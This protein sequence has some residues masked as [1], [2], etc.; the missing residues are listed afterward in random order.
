MFLSLHN[1]FFFLVTWTF[2]K[3]NLN[4]S[5]RED[6]WQYF[7]YCHWS[8]NC[9]VALNFNTFFTRKTHQFVSAWYMLLRQILILEQSWAV[10]SFFSQSIRNLVTTFHVSGK[11]WLESFSLTA[12][13]LQQANVGPLLMEQPHSPKVN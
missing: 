8:A 2:R 4:L 11:K 6:V 3:N 1:L 12:I 7:S 9:M 13:W 5:P 10:K